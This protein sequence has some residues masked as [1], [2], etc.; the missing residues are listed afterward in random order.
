MTFTL[1]RPPNPADLVARLESEAKS[2][3][4]EALYL[5]TETAD[6]Y[7]AKKGYTAISREIVPVEIK[8]SSE[9]SHVCPVSAIVMKKELIDTLEMKNQ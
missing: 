1:R 3:G 6:K 5:L 7:F 8:S 9:F 4:I 2:S